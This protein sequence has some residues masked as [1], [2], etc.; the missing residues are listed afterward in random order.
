MPLLTQG[1]GRL[2]KSNEP[3]VSRQSE[4]RLVLGYGR[5]LSLGRRRYARSRAHTT[6]PNFTFFSH[7]S[8]HFNA[9][10]AEVF[11]VCLF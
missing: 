8:T 10:L 4:S 2:S 11:I 6:F 5:I 7:S 1:R 3:E 9:P